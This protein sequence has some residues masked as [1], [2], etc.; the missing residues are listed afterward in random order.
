MTAQDFKGIFSDYLIAESKN[1]QYC[2]YQIAG[3]PDA[4]FDAFSEGIN[5]VGMVGDIEHCAD[6]DIV[7]TVR[8]D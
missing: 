2:G 6:D 1:G 4:V 8:F 3:M 5:A 7:Y